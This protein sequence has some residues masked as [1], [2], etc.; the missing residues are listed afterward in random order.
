MKLTLNEAW[1]KCPEMYKWIADI[2]VIGDDV[3]EYK[4]DWLRENDSDADLLCNCYFCEYAGE[5][6]FG[7]TVCDNCPGVLVDPTF[8]CKNSEYHYAI[9]PVAFYHK[10]VALNKVRLEKSHA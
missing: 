6:D 3:D 9:N 5:D 7:D 8:D 2:Y 10:I 1:E 4:Y